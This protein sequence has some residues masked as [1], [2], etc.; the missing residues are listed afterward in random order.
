MKERITKSS[1]DVIVKV[2]DACSISVSVSVRTIGW[3]RICG[4]AVTGCSLG[5]KIQ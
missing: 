3:V 4:E 5:Y 2:L 1:A